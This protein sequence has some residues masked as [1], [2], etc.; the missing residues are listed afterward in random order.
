MEL[1]RATGDAIATFAFTT[2]PGVCAQATGAARQT[3][4]QVKKNVFI[5]SFGLF[6]MVPWNSRLIPP[7]GKPFAWLGMTCTRDF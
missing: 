7:R 2:C 4:I 1:G 3:K 5:F 6:I